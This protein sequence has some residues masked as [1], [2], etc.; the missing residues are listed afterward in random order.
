FTAELCRESAYQESFFFR[1][2][3]FTG[4]GTADPAEQLLDAEYREPET[5]Y[6]ATEENALQPGALPPLPAMLALSREPYFLRDLFERKIFGERGLARSVSRSR[7]SRNR[8]ILALQ[9]A[10]I[11]VLLIG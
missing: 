7:L 5:S 10:T 9:I 11:A 3:Y 1:G 4:D 2:L 8:T 6:T